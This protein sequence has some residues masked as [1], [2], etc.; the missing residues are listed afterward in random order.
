MAYSPALAVA[1]PAAPRVLLVEDHEMAARG[2]SELLSGEG[3]EVA[4]AADGPG[5][6]EAASLAA[7]DAVVLD[8]LLPGLTGFDVCRELRAREATRDIAILM[9]TGLGDTPSKLQGFDIGADDYLVKPI[10][11]RE[12]A[13]RIR[14]LLSARRQAAHEVRRQRLR[15]IGEITT[16]VG[17]E[18]NNPL[19]TAIGTIE[20]VLLRRDLSAEVRRDLDVCQQQLWRIAA[21]VSELGE[22]RDETVPYVGPDTMID[23]TPESA[24][25]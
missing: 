5:A 10:A 4:R 11:S 18:I 16:A 3:F 9:L 12:L 2:L 6:L 21:T 1:P 20:M 24:R 19:A 15:A 22:V 13:A 17:H 23:L 25:H 8:V 14:K 7:F